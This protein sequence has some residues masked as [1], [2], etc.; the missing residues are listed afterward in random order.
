MLKPFLLCA[1]LLSSSAFADWQL[2]NSQSD[3]SIT[4]IKQNS[5][6]EN[7]HFTQL[8]GT[9]SDD[10]QLSFS[11]DLKSIETLIPIRNQR[12]Q[13]LLFNVANFP[14][15]IVKADLSSYLNKLTN[16]TQVI[17]SVPVKLSLHGHEQILKVDLVVNKKS[18]QLQ[19]T[20][21]RV[22]LV[23]ASD[24]NLVAGIES[25]RKVAGLD[26]IATTVPVTFS[27]VFNEQVN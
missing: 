3:L 24:F 25:L 13:A 1:S 7:H 11:I 22:V 21:L 5:I 17:K 26:S 18:Q 15:A 2:D 19:V 20:P 4:S 6:A 14:K 27:L 9:L 12:M 23:R 8:N 16:G 10:G